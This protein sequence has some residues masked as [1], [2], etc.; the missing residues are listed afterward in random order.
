[1]QIVFPFLFLHLSL[2]ASTES[3]VWLIF[4]NKVISKKENLGIIHKWHPRGE[5]SN[6]S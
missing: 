5:G 6:R 3:T 1:M 4:E 2:H